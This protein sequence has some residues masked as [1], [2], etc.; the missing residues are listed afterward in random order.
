AQTGKTVIISS[1]LTEQTD[2]EESIK[3]LKDN[4]CKDIILLQ[5]TSSY[6]APANES[7][8]LTIP[9]MREI[10][11]CHIGLSDHTPGIGVAVGSVALGTRLI[12]KHLKLKGDNTG[13]DAAFSLDPDTF[14]LMV[15]EIGRAY[16][17][18]GKVDFTIQESEKNSLRFKRSI[19]SVVDIAKG[20][21]ITEDNIRIIRPSG[22][23]APK[24][25]DEILGKK[26]VTDIRAG[27]PL[28]FEVIA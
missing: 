21:I 13:V 24:H 2:I 20:E 17:A 12:E 22:G 10:F 6:P 1:G 19:Y 14:G 27:S 3:I 5:C 7:N 15:E 4:G 23:L 8:L 16:E 25:F 9:A 18:L 26:A 11:N 28:T